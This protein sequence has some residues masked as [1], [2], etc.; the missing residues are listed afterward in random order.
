MN[1]SN[2]QPIIEVRRGQVVE[3]I[4][5][6]AFTVV[7]TT[8]RVVANYGNPDTI[9]YLRSAAKPFQALPFIEKGG[10]EFF[11][12][13]DKEVAVMC[14]SHSGTDEHVATIKGMQEKIGMGEGD[15]LCG[16]HPSYHEPTAVRMIK[17]GDLPTPN[18]HNCSGKHT[19]MVAHALL[20]QLP[21][22]DYINFN[23]PVQQSILTAFAEM[24]SMEEQ[25][26]DLGIDGCSAPNFA[27]PMRSAA[28]AF[29]RLADPTGLPDQRA[30]A[31]FRIRR[32]MMGHPDMVGGP[33][34]F[35]TKLMQ[36][37]E[38]KILTKA[39]ADGYQ[40]LA[41]LPGALGAGSP[42]LGATLKISDGD[43]GNRAKVTAVMALLEQL[44]ALDEDKISKL[45]EFYTRPIYNWRHL[46]VGD[47]HPTFQ[48]E[49]KIS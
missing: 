49:A 31:L 46:D 22:Q 12:L 11:G 29:A 6:G 5:F 34:R 44:G 15:L 32:S 9:T 25:A 16:T 45:S 20:R 17:A 7:D 18:R 43:A 13:T 26:V 33:D 21:K 35:D 10:A 4:H 23:H 48:I 41:L 38:G 1:Q 42:A 27:V 28:L 19:G 37:F 24:C 39:G 14:A 47:I 3:S 8:G 40:A 2:Y 36:V 30:E